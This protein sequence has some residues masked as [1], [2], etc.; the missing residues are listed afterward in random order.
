MKKTSNSE[1]FNCL[2]GDNQI[3]L[4]SEFE[5][6]STYFDEDLKKR[7][8]CVGKENGCL[9]CKKDMNHTPV[10]LA[11]IIDRSDGAIKIGKFGWTATKQMLD[12]ATKPDYEYETMPAYD[13]IITK[14]G[15][16]LQ[17]KYDVVASRKDTPLTEE[18]AAKVKEV[19]ET[20]SL[21]DI[22]AKMKDRV[23][24]ELQEQDTPQKPQNAPR[25]A[26][27]TKNDEMVI[28]PASVYSEGNSDDI[29]F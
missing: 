16:K 23:L 9:G 29:T 25:K 5:P 4:L 10:F 1:W 6:Y 7:F 27:K 19:L 11:W 24:N 21:L 14:S 20:K 26:E 28:E 17:T 13:F 8:I 18:E 12:H 22:I 15:Q 3:K 2:E